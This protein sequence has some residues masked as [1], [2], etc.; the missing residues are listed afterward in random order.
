[1]K[2]RAA[3]AARLFC[4]T[5]IQEMVYLD[6]IRL[7]HL[8]TRMIAHRGLSGIER[9]NTNAAFVAAGNRSYFG[10]ETDV[11]K[12]ADGKFVIIHDEDTV[13]V[14]GG[15]YNIQVEN[16]PLDAAQQI[17][18]PDLDG[19]KRSDL[20]VPTLAEYVRICKKYEKTCVLELKNAF[21]QEDICAI[22]KIISEQEYL[23]H[24]IF[25]SFVLQNC[26]ILRQ[27]LPEQLIQWLTAQPIDEQ[28]I[29]TLV[30]HRLGLDSEYHHLTQAI[31]AQLHRHG[32][33]VNCWTCND[34]QAGA[35]LVHMGVDYITTNIL[36]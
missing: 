5:D 15:K 11:H 35:D 19:L 32:I 21:A 22:V 30:Q 13:R 2:G 34:A 27:L 12:T 26:I 14:S 23:D 1:M 29:Q 6:T 24:V 33:V 36:E 7:E 16:S 28:L 17:C 10:V 18:L 4:K 20:R 25:I 3:P 31:V 9:E 8:H